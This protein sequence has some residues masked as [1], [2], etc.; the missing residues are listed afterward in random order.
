M[1]ELYTHNGRAVF[2]GF[3]LYLC[4]LNAFHISCFENVTYL[5][6]IDIQ[7]CLL[8]MSS[9][10]YWLWKDIAV[11]KGAAFVLTILFVHW[12]NSSEY[13]FV[14]LMYILYLVASLCHRICYQIWNLEPSVTRLQPSSIGI[15]YVMLSELAT[16]KQN[17]HKAYLNPEFHPVEGNG[18]HKCNV[19]CYI[20]HIKQLRPVNPSKVYNII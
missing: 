7:K 3:F 1:I 19:V 15:K 11:G 5:H 9:A 13:V 2:A 16:R 17:N 20:K 14:Q 18:T 4:F 6:N 8:D 10:N 12:R